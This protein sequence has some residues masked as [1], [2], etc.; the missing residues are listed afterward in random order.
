MGIYTAE[1][2][3][4]WL[5]DFSD[6]Y[7]KERVPWIKKRFKLISIIFITL[8]CTEVNYAK[9]DFYKLENCPVLTSFD[10][11]YALCALKLLEISERT[12]VF[13]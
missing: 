9:A 11:E 12:I 8:H 2:L 3:V 10:I 13:L 4:R 1:P 6:L 5:K 7:E